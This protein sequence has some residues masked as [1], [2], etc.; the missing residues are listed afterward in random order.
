MKLESLLEGL[1]ISESEMNF[2]FGTVRPRSIEPLY[3]GKNS[4][5]Y[6]VID[7]HSNACVLK[8]FRS[9]ERMRRELTFLELTNN[10]KITSVPSILSKIEKTKIIK[11]SF[12]RGNRPDSIDNNLID[13]AGNFISKINSPTKPK[14]SSLKPAID[15]Y[16]SARDLLFD[17]RKRFD[18]F[19]ELEFQDPDLRLTLTQYMTRLKEFFL[20]EIRNHGADLNTIDF[21]NTLLSP[22]DFN[23]NNTVFG[24]GVL[25]FIDFEYSGY[26]SSFKLCLDFLL[27]PNHFITQ[28]LFLRFF[29]IL[30]VS[31]L[32]DHSDYQNVNKLRKLGIIKWSLILLNSLNRY[33]NTRDP[34]LGP[35]FAAIENSK[36]YF[37]RRFYNND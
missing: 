4:Y 26:D 32:A 28:Q 3:G 9:F 21:C 12:I 5:V 14:L 15:N 34:H 1:K 33:K 23:F 35:A 17:I 29:K 7:G 27:Q 8:R 22:S 24:N 31:H 18:N 37:Q 10:L 2:F 30:Q 25:S 11:L 19:D 20:S 16:H 6:R 36:S 13:Q